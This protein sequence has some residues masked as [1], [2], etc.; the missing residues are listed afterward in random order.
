M[1][2]VQGVGITDEGGKLFSGVKF[3]S[4]HEHLLIGGRYDY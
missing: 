3:V 4:P 1:S 2:S